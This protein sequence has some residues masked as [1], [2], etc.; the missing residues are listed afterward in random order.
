MDE[1]KKNN[2]NGGIEGFR[3]CSELI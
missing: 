2:L 1:I 3:N